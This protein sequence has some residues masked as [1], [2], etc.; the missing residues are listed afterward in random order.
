MNK[1]S[2]KKRVKI[3]HMLL[4]GTSM[5]ATSRINKVSFNA[6]ARLLVNGG[7]VCFLHHM[8]TVREV[9]AS[10]IQCDELWSFCFAK[11]KNARYTTVG[12][13]G[14]GDVWTWTAIE[15]DT[16]LWISYKVGDRTDRAAVSLMK[17][18]KSRLAYI[19]KIQINTDGNVSYKKAIRTIF[20]RQVKYAQLVKEF[21]SEPSIT[22]RRVSGRPSKKCTSTSFVER[23][24]LTIRMGVRRYTR[25]TNA[26]SKKIENHRHMIAL[27]ATYYNFIRVHMTL[28]TT[29]ALAAGLAD[30]PY[31]LEWLVDMI[32]DYAPK[33]KRPKT[34]RT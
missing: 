3:L 18:L 5:R 24:N 12:P 23:H 30:E 16:K 28:G 32:D 2:T 6:V 1:L 33:P 34:Y 21:G 7:K 26:F 19:E 14:A 13:R 20:G 25:K 9:E 8:Y 22:K 11:Q 27:F 31:T 15:A 29:P 4:E 17:D 10:L